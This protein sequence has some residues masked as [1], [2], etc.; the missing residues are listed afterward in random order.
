VVLGGKHFDLLSTAYT[1]T[2]VNRGTRLDIQVRYRVSTNFNWYANPWARFL[3][4]DTASAILTF[5][6]NR[7]EADNQPCA[8]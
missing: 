4:S 5:Y 8:A 1:L 3:V 6:K 2:P 7:A